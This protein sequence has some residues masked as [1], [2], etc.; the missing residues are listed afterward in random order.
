MKKINYLILA[1]VISIIVSMS[2]C[3]G[4]NGNNTTGNLSTSEVKANVFENKF[5]SFEV[6]ND[7]LRIEDKSND[8][9]LYIAFYDGDEYGGH[10]QGLGDNKYT[11][12]AIDTL[13]SSLGLEETTVA[14]YRALIDDTEYTKTLHV[15]PF[16]NAKNP[17][18]QINIAFSTDF[19]SYYEKVKN[20]FVIKEFP[21]G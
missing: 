2:G 10:I 4:P 20:S 17:Q 6:P 19:S 12:D 15:F 13:A 18:S 16:D 11:D 9:S 7:D 14:G 1:L 5:V 8:T 21:T 3:T